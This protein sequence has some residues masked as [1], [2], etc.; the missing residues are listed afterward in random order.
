MIK[1]FEKLPIILKIIKTINQIIESSIKM[2]IY[3]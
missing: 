3:I 2:Y 1:I